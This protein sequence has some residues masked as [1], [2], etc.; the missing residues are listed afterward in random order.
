LAPKNV[1]SD[2]SVAEAC[3]LRYSEELAVAEKFQSHQPANTKTAKTKKDFLP[4]YIVA[5]QWIAALGLLSRNMFLSKAV[6][7]LRPSSALLA[8]IKTLDQLP[9][10]HTVKVALFHVQSGVELESQLFATD[11]MGRQQEVSKNYQI[12]RSTLGWTV[13]IQKHQQ[14]GGYT[15]GLEPSDSTD[16]C[17]LYYGD[18]AVEVAW[19]ESV[20]LSPAMTID[21]K[22]RALGNHLVHV[23]WSENTRKEWS[24]GSVRAAVE[25]VVSMVRG[26]A[27]VV[28][29]RV[30]GPVALQFGPLAVN[31]VSV[32]PLHVIGTLIRAT[33]VSAHAACLAH[34]SRQPLLHPYLLSISYTNAIVDVRNE[35]WPW[36]PS[37]PNME[38]DRLQATPNT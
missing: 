29:V 21:E 8:D 1:E 11:K 32:Q 19:H 7:P 27:G 33:V 24:P 38:S 5:R 35:V 12:F 34:L 31:T 26:E 10:R 22:R 23:V 25:I 3:R 4:P 6:K 36:M 16:S 9:T 14:I 37:K 20:R 17:M 13:D 2:K 15:A 18:S 28:R 30:N